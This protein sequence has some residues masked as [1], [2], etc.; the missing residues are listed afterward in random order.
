[1]IKNIFASSY[2]LINMI[3]FK[4]AE[5][6]AQFRKNARRKITEISKEINIP[7]TTIYDK[8]AMNEK[9]GLFRRHV[10]II[11]FNKLGMFYKQHIVIKTGKQNKR[12]LEEFLLTHPNI[13]S[14]YKLNLGSDFLVETIF[15]SLD[16]F[17]RFIENIEKLGSCDVQVNQIAEELRKESF[18]SNPDDL[19]LIGY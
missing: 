5:I 6:I 12:E 4:D 14:L 17:E 3:S 18:L 15:R 13:N 11:D 2:T 16:E 10:T 7:A 9:K 1:M 8:V 19:R